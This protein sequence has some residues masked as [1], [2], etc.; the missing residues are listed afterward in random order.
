MIVFRRFGFR[1]IT[2]VEEFFLYRSVGKEI[3]M[4]EENLFDWVDF[5]EE[6]AR[7]LLP[8]KDNRQELI[9]QIYETY[10]TA[11]VKLPLLENGYKI[12]DID[13]FTVIGLFNRSNMGGTRGVLVSAFRKV[14]GVVSPEPTAGYA[15]IPL[16]YPKN[17]T[18]YPFLPER[19]GSDIDHHWDLFES[20]LSYADGPSQEN[21]DRFIEDF[22]RAIYV[23]G[24]GTGKLTMGLYWIASDTFLNLDSR[25]I[26]YIYESK[27]V[28]PDVLDKIPPLKKVE[29]KIPG[30]DY[31]DFV[32]MMRDYLS[33]A[34]S[35]PR[36]FR[37]MSHTAWLHTGGTLKDVDSARKEARYWIYA[38]GQDASR[39]DEFHKDGI[40]AVDWNEIGDLANFGEKKQISE[41]L[42]ETF[43]DETSYSNDAL[44]L[45]QF[46]K[47]MKPGDVVFAKK[48]KMQ[49]VGRGVVM[50]DYKYEESRPSFQHVRKVHWTYRGE[51]PITEKSLPLKTLTDITSGPEYV[52][53]LSKLVVE[54]ISEP[55]SEKDFLRE[56]YMNREN[57]RRLAKLVRY[58]KNVILQG[59]PGVGKTFIAKRLAYSMMGFKDKERVM[60]VQFHQS[61]SYEDFVMGFRPTEHGFK[62]HNGAFY[63]FCQV[64][65]K[66]SDHEYFFIIDEINRGNLSKI[67]GELFMLIENDKR[68]KRIRPLYRDE[69]FS[70]PSNLYLIGTMNTADRS[71]A[72]LDFALRRRFAFYGIDPGFQTDGFRRYQKNLDSAVFDKLV[73]TVENLNEAIATDE[74][75]GEGFQIGHSYFCDLQND[76]EPMFPDIVEYKLIPL[77]K[78]YW[79][80]DPGKV[81]DWANQLRNALK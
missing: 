78:E 71:L 63:D 11:D 20:A 21:R 31:L 59:P 37:E 65:E 23:K 45:W 64:A 33:E 47:E 18:F 27:E 38:P 36:N 58:S 15:G 57:Y 5:Y 35:G 2:Q 34:V 73:R 48:G 3:E 68:N 22:D 6:F 79:F 75:L 81:R 53:Y 10:R 24:V 52:K 9:A 80:D 4:S 13:P 7:A 43:G 1:K 26:D 42:K 72:M 55:Y 16:L 70:V 41:E 44:C 29:K 28:P 46:A 61:Y 74:S 69:L 50:S 17:A 77:L 62:L 8:Y 39:W 60:T 32:E 12:K 54:P 25:N 66:D 67:F 14:F 76:M 56:V 19:K 40:M 30:A 49:I 51:W